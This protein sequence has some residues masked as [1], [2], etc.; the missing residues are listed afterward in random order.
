[1]NYSKE[2]KFSQYIFT[3]SLLCSIILSFILIFTRVKL[4]ATAFLCLVLIS[5]TFWFLISYLYGIKRSVTWVISL[6]VLNLFIV[7]PELGL[8]VAGFRYESGIQQFMYPNPTQFL[9][10]YVPDKKLFWKLPSSR[11]DINSLGFPGK[12][13]TI[14]KPKNV[15]RILFLGDSCTQQGYPDIVETFLNAKHDNYS[16]RFESITL[17]IAGYSSYQ[18]RILAE[19]YGSEFEPDLVIVYYGWN[20]HWLALGSIDSEKVL[21]LQEKPW[22]KISNIIY[23]KVRLLQAIKKLIVSVKRIDSNKP[24]DEV[25]VPPDQYSKN[26]LKI[27][28]IFDNKNI[29]IVLITAPTSHYRLGVPD[30]LVE[31]KAIANKQSIIEMHKMYNQIVREIARN[32]GVLILDLESEFDENENIQEI[33]ST[34]GIHFTSRGLALVAKQV[35]GFMEINILT[36]KIE[37]P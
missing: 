15:Y 24:I 26:L 31:I 23:K 25:R 8:R 2:P 10:E 16:K 18:G 30:Y 34:D 27:I 21:Y 11:P 12:E 17:A 22:E 32:Y 33:F 3:G 4:Y 35:A 7:V 9:S 29:P 5:V 14:P 1:M 37:K 20:D 13:I 19:L 6:A 28:K 36:N